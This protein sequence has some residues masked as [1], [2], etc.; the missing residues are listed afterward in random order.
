[1]TA[2]PS[3]PRRLAILGLLPGPHPLPRDLGILVE[4]LLAAGVE[5]DLLVPPRASP[6]ARLGAS[7]E[8][9]AEREGLRSFVLDLADLPA[10]AAALDAYVRARLPDLLLSNR[11]RASALLAQQPA[12]GLCRVARIGTDVLEKTRAKLPWVRWW[13]R[14]HLA[15]VLAGLDGL[16]GV[17][18]G[19]CAA[20]RQLLGGSFGGVQGR[21]SAPPVLRSYSPLDLEAI[22]RLAAAPVAHPWFAGKDRPVFVSVGR[23]VRAKDYPTLIRAFGRVRQRR[24]C[25][26]L[27][28]G[29][30]RQHARLRALVRRLD[31]AGEVD[32]PGFA[33]NPFPY[34]AQA[35]GF[36]LSSRFEGFGNVLAEALALGTPCVSTDCHSGPRE[37]LGDGLHGRLVPVG[38]VAA[39]ARAMED[40][41]ERPR[42]PEPLRAAAARFARDRVVADLLPALGALVCVRASGGG[43]G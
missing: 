17:S 2:V 38:A 31:L 12:C 11:D 21:R 42:A 25:R 26:L 4:G 29:E 19:A 3:W 14:R 20:L 8:A 6:S 5:V 39:L 36:V 30:G 33:P 35:D 28:L 22:D 10:A 37:I 43:R 23:L 41:L 16:I 18:D 7:Q 1:M 34:M 24:L 32:L 40:T 15:H 27:I 9:L 13:K